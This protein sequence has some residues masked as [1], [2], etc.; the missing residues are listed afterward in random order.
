M[1]PYYLG[2]IWLGISSKFFII[3]LETAQPVQRHLH[4]DVGLIC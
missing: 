3:A 4:R 2:A 1:M